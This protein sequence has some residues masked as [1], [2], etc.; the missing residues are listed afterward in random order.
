MNQT[1]SDHERAFMADS[2]IRES[3]LRHDCE[4]RGWRLVKSW[5]SEEDASGSGGF[6]VIESVT[7]AVVAGGSPRAFSMTHDD[8]R[9]LAVRPKR[10]RR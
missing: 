7:G 3:R 8:V 9:N 10:T 6:M 5:R 1:T 4:R 2:S